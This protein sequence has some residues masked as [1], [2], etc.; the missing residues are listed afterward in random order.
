[1]NIDERPLLLF[2]AP[3]L[4]SRAK[5]GGGSSDIKFPG[6]ER[7]VRRLEPQ[8]NT[9]IDTFNRRQAELSDSPIGTRPEQVLVL[10]TVGSVTD[11]IKA[12]RNIRGMNWLV[13]LDDITIDPDEDFYYAEEKDSQKRLRGELFLIMS[14]QSAMRQ[15]ESLWK[16]FKKDCNTSFPRGLA[17]WRSLFNQLKSI[18]HW[19]IDDRLR[20]TGAIE[21]WQERVKEN[22]EVVT[23]EIEAWFKSDVHE[24][25]LSLSQI[26]H[27]VREE[28]GQILQETVIEEIAYHG[29]LCQLPIASIA[30]FLLNKQAKL[31]RCDQ[32]MFFRPTGQVAVSSS[33]PLEPDAEESSL[34]LEQSHEGRMGPPV[35]AIFDGLPLANHSALEGKLVVDDPDGWAAEYQAGERNHGTGMASLI[36]NGDLSIQQPPLSRKVY[37]RPVMKPIQSDW[38]SPR[39]E[40]LPEDELTVD[41]VHRAVV[42]MFEGREGEA[43]AAPTVKIINLSIADWYLPF[44]KFVSP[45]A[46]L[47]DWLSWKYNVLFVISAGNQCDS[48]HIGMPANDFRKLPPTKQQQLV[49]KALADNARNRRILSPAESINALTVG[50]AHSDFSIIQ[51]LG[52]RMNLV[53]HDSMFSPISASGFGFR[54]SIKPE[55]LMP[56]GRQLYVQRLD[57]TPSRTVLETSRARAVPPGIR[58]AAP[59]SSGEQNRTIYTCGTSNA[60]ALTSRTGA[61]LFDMLEDLREQDDLASEIIEPQYATVL[62]KALL[63]HGADWGEALTHIEDSLD[64]KIEPKKRRQALRNE[65]ARLLGYGNVTPHKVFECESDRATLIGCGILNAEDGHRYTL[66]LPSCLNGSLA[67]RKL[68][69]TLAW[70]TPI[71]FAHQRYRQAHLWFD[72]ESDPLDISRSQ[73]DHRAVRR[74]T[75]QHEIF[76]GEEIVRFKNDQSIGIRVS[77]RP[78]AGASQLVVPYGLVVSLSAPSLPIYEQVRAK[79]QVPIS[80]RASA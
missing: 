41:L 17:K 63:V 80:I 11:F 75:V 61:Q 37:V 58:V 60:A 19:D 33:E 62:L 54:R 56:G 67:N 9:L 24:R 40:G 44:F 2:P 7:Q 50:A 38:N 77:C 23:V 70:L 47:I 74:G 27:C 26:E 52:D 69:V 31:L 13:G 20:E 28:H 42:R 32:V 45:L 53:L 36:T 4:V 48:I 22:R 64:L 72:A 12:V 5:L 73:A 65:L 68:S 8:F 18:R 79:I 29:L 3:H 6:G 14:N 35:V 46:R 59:G 66:P 30:T 55:I 16:K 51:N 76:E 10:E 71:N 49:V 34:E 1:M 43:P 21:D 57:G 39:R 15:L 25:A 78:D